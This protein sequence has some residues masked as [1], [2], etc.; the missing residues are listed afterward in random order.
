M[1][2]RPFRVAIIGSGP[3]GFFTAEALLKSNTSFHI[4]IIEELPFPFG[5][6]RYGVAPDHQQTKKVGERFNALLAGKSV[7]FIG[8]VK[9]GHDI[10]I[11]ELSDYYDL[12]I[13]ATGSLDGKPLKIAGTHLSG[14]HPASAFVTW[15][16]GHPHY[17]LTDFDLTTETAVVIGNGNVALDAARLLAKSADALRSS[18][19]P[20]KILKHLAQSRIKTVYLIGRRG[21]LQTSFSTKE[22]RELAELSDCDLLVDPA[23]LILNPASQTELTLK[24]N[25]RHQQNYTALTT[26]S[27]RQQSGMKRRIII[28][29]LRQPHA[30]EGGRKVEKLI[31]EKTVLSGAPGQQS[32]TGNGQYEEIPC[33]LVLSAIGHRSVP[34]PDVPFDH[35]MGIIPNDRGR[36][37]RDGIPIPGYYVSGWIKTGAQG[38]I[39]AN[40]RDSLLTVESILTDLSGIPACPYPDTPALIQLLTDRGL[41]VIQAKDWLKMDRLE[42][43]RGLESGKPREK[44]C[45]LP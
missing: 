15:V 28:Q 3:G 27:L 41:R 5:L 1:Q 14:C 2:T 19:I 40:K 36:V 34:L 30:I 31:L 16:N 42:K 35:V 38:L 10:R 9:A 26:F 18:D 44:F 25:Y 24:E 4:D 45:A 39:G 29:F 7:G 23:D 32:P 17:Q 43:E 13:F 8:N 12:L 11:S 21:P 20:E 22:L 37:L 6:I 33:G